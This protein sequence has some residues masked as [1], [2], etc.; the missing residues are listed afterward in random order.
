METK[1]LS[2]LLY[3]LCYDMIICLVGDELI[4]FFHFCFVYDIVISNA[5]Y[6]NII[7]LFV[8]LVTGFIILMNKRF[9]LHYLEEIGMICC[10][11]FIFVVDVRFSLMLILC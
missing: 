10:C 8:V 1:E 2:I 4:L 3:F 6:P 5:S 9:N 11:G 7:T